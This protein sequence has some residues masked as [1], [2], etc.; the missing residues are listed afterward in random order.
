MLIFARSFFQ[1][2]LRVLQLDSR[3]IGALYRFVVP[4]LRNAG[5]QGQQG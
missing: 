1:S 4:T 2:D 3:G 5:A